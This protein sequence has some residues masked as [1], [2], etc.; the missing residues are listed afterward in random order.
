MLAH[1]SSP[2]IHLRAL[3]LAACGAVADCATV[4]SPAPQVSMSREAMSRGQTVI[5]DDVLLNTGKT[6]LLITS[7]VKAW[8]SSAK[9]KKL[10]APCN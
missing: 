10:P 4:V 6:D 2:R 3:L 5:F 7:N 8:Q 9:L 1:V